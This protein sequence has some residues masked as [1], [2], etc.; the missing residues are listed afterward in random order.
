MDKKIKEVGKYLVLML[1]SYD[2]GG[3]DSKLNWKRGAFKDGEIAVFI[4]GKEKGL[5]K[6]TNYKSLAQTEKV[7]Q[8]LCSEEKIENGNNRK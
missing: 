7:Y 8:S 4:K 2:V 1:V 6:R 3:Y 5:Q